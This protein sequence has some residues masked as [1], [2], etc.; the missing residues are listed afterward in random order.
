MRKDIETVS[1]KAFDNACRLQEHKN[2]REKKKSL[3]ASSMA[4]RLNELIVEVAEG[5]L[6]IRSDWK[7]VLKNM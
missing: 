6:V 1:H 7:K 4:N 3:S 5:Y 2:L